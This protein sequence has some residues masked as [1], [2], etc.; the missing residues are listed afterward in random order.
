MQVS[1]LR[2][3]VDGLFHTSDA[4]LEGILASRNLLSSWEKLKTGLAALRDVYGECGGRVWYIWGTSGVLCLPKGKWYAAV[5]Y[6]KYCKT[7]REGCVYMEWSMA[8]GL[9]PCVCTCACC[10]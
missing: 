7:R 2:W 8:M 5:V 4:E 3:T 9:P 1:D 10:V 6:L